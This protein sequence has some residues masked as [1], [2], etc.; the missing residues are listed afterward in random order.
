MVNEMTR[1]SFLNTSAGAIAAAF[2]SATWLAAGLDGAV[3]PQR[4]MVGFAPATDGTLDSF[5]M[6]ME[7]LSKSGFR[8]VEVDN[9]AIKLAE[10]YGSRLQE[11]RERMAKLN[12]RLVGVNQGYRFAD[13]SAREQIKAQNTLVAAFLQNVN[14]IYLGWQG[15]LTSDEGQ[16][17]AER[18]EE[19]RRIARLAN[20]EG[21]RLAEEFGIKFCYHTHSTLGFRR[22][23]DLTRPEALSLNADLGWLLAR[24]GADAMEVCRAYRSRLQTLHFKDFDPNREFTDRGQKGK[25]G[26]VVPGKGKVDFPAVVQF[27]KETEFEGCVLGEHIGIGNYDFVRSPREGEVYP[28]V[29]EDF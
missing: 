21:R 20:V 23:L 7:A 1:R 4:F 28:Q 11:F 22:L 29:Q 24:G 2:N 9:G 26:M 17:R 8:F 14:A 19:L 25:G 12:L 3:A 27:L 6:R 13:P 10:S 16:E 18:E 5:W 15:A